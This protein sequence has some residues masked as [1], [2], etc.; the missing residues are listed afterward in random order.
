[1]IINFEGEERKRGKV[2]GPAKIC[3]HA[4]NSRTADLA[5]PRDKHILWLGSYLRSNYGRSLCGFESW[6]VLVN[7]SLLAESGKSGFISHSDPP[8]RLC[9]RSHPFTTINA[10]PTRNPSQTVVI[11]PPQT[12][13]SYHSHLTVHATTGAD[14][15]DSGKN[16]RR[17]FL[18]TIRHQN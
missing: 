17:I 16:K 11:Q 13:A 18:G 6:Y 8:G 7:A 14:D 1:M 4:R 9:I 5:L 3:V 15:N 10:K 2:Y 12:S